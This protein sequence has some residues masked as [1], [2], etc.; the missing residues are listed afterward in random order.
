MLSV[1]LVT[2]LAG[3]TRAVTTTGSPDLGCSGLCSADKMTGGGCSMNVELR[4]PGV[5]RCHFGI[6]AGCSCREVG[7]EMRRLELA[8][9]PELRR[10]DRRAAWVASAEFGGSTRLRILMMRVRISPGLSTLGYGP[11]V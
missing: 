11:G 10:A 6:G 2:P 5:G 9:K 1:R 7:T 8:G 4:A 3:I